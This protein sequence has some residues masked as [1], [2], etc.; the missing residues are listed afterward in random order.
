M[1]R[2]EQVGIRQLKA[3]ASHL[4]DRVAEERAT[5]TITRRGRAVGILAPPD[6][7]PPSPALSGE[8]AWDRVI[9]LADQLTSRPGTKRRSAV[10]EL[11][12]TRR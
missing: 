3:K 9:A 8:Q 7:V 4:V 2:R 1:K 12:K 6:Y 11:Q 5:Y 10:R